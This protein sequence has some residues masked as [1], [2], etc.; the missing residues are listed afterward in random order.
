MET[1]LNI[2]F[3][4][5]L[6]QTIERYDG[7]HFKLD[8]MTENPVLHLGYVLAVLNLKESFPEQFNQKFPEY[9]H[10]KSTLKVCRRATIPQQKWHGLLEHEVHYFA[11]NPSV[12]KDDEMWMCNPG[13][14]VIRSILLA[15]HFLDLRTK[16]ADEIN[17]GNFTYDRFFDRAAPYIQVTYDTGVDRFLDDSASIGELFPFIERANPNVLTK[18]VDHTRSTSSSETRSAREAVMRHFDDREYT[19]EEPRRT[20][21]F[22]IVNSKA[23]LLAMTF[24]T[25]LTLVNMSWNGI[26]I[27]PGNPLSDKIRDG[28]Q[29][30]VWGVILTRQ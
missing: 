12:D 7:T 24:D 23:D 2:N 20:L 4:K 30:L 21:W 18:A 5:T 14:W 13:F 16:W 11:E 26:Q 28:E 9:Q 25:Y 1:N 10:L 6:L 15:E 3:L 17:A 27:Q 29:G 19:F 8:Q 22:N